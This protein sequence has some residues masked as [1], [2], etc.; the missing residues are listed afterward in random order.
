ME[1]QSENE[2][3]AFWSVSMND[4]INVGKSKRVNVNSRKK[5]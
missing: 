5:I 3:I 4:I 1:S 2:V